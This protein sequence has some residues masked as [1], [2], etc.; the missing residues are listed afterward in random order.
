MLEAGKYTRQFGLGVV[1]NQ[2]HFDGPLLHSMSGPN[3][4]MNPTIRLYFFPL[5]VFTV[6]F[7]KETAFKS[8]VLTMYSICTSLFY[9]NEKKAHIYKK[10]RTWIRPRQ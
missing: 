8:N 4:I 1:R 6:L 3:T 7:L 2:V 10:C 5:F 9:C